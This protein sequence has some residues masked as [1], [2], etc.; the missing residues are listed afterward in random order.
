MP[1]TLTRIAIAGSSFVLLALGACASTQECE[2]SCSDGK[3]P[4][5]T[6]AMAE[7]KY[8]EPTSIRYGA[9]GTETW[10]W[11]DQGIAMKF[12][13]GVAIKPCNN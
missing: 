5:T 11:E 3:I 12:L 9:D 6:I 4:H 2:S 1:R 7:E 8:G 13:D 10:T